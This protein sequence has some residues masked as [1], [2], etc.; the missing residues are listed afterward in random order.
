[1][2]EIGEL[3]QDMQFKLLQAIQ[4]GKV[5]QVGARSPVKVNIRLI[6]ATNRDFQQ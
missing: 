1:L 4:E 6:S 2:D 3:R 5:D